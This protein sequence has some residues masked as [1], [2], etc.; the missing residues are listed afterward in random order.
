MEET[1][2]RIDKSLRERKRNGNGKEGKA[3]Q[4]KEKQGGRENALGV[5]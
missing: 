2:T 4:C 1:K 5:F 3:R